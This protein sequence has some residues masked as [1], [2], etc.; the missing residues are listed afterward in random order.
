M[1]A[2]PYAPRFD[3]RLSGVTL[4]ADLADQVLSLTVESDLDLAGSF[5][6][7]LHNHDN[8]LLDSALLECRQDRRDPPRLRAGPGPGVPRRDRL[9]RAVVPGRRA[10]DDHGLRGTTSRT[11]CGTPSRSRA[12]YGDLNDSL[13]A[14]QIAAENGLT[15]IVDPVPFH[16]DRVQV[17][18]DMAFL[19][20]C[21]AQYFFDVYV[22]WD[23]CTSTSR[24]RSSSAHTL[25]W[26]KNLSSFSPRIS[27]T[28]LAG[29]QRSGSTTR[30]SRRR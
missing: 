3:V 20:A 7:S 2:P 14:A 18:T 6:L 26:G 24:G 25:E 15:P 22:E 28:G 11:G 27:A 21:A 4:A 19:K 12:A 9:D 5:S 17:E 23:G 16:A 29:V 1:R 30:S 10:T 8:A 13:I